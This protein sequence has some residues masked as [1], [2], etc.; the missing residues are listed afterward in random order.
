MGINFRKLLRKFISIFL[1]I[2]GNLLKN[3]FILFFKNYNHIIYKK[4][5][6]HFFDKQLSRYLCFNFMHYVQ[7]NNLLSLLT[8]T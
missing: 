1:E 8:C 2:S 5:G 3:F 4:Y 7:K 6:M